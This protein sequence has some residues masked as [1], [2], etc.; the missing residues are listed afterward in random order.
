MNDNLLASLQFKLISRG[1]EPRED[2]RREMQP[3]DQG[4]AYL[5][6]GALFCLIGALALSLVILLNR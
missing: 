2:M 6:L 5:I 1:W 4:A 3:H